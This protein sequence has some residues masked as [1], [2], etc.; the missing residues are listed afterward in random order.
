[1]GEVR[2]QE[3]DSGIGTP[4]RQRW[5]RLI[6]VV[7]VTYSLAYLDRSNFS[8]ASASGMA[9]NLHPTSATSGLV[10]ASFFLGYFHVAG[11]RRDVC[12]PP[13]RAPADLLLGAGMGRAGHCARPAQL[14]G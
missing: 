13:Q 3:L 2:A 11:A 7:F 10:G 9:A 12:G 4:G 14:G 6:P 1:M 5:L 8:I